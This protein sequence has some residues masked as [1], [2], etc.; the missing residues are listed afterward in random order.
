MPRRIHASQCDAHDHEKQRRPQFSGL[1][2]T[3]LPH[4]ERRDQDGRQRHF[5]GLH[6][7]AVLAQKIHGRLVLFRQACDAFHLHLHA[8]FDH[9]GLHDRGVDSVVAGQDRLP[10]DLEARFERPVRVGDGGIQ[11][12]HRQVARSVGDIQRRGQQAGRRCQLDPPQPLQQAQGTAFVGGGVRCADQA[13][14]G[15]SGTDGQRMETPAAILLGEILLTGCA[16]ARPLP[17]DMS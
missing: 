6:R 1:K 17:P 13:P 3:G 7:R 9:A 12:L 2:C 10:V 15:K 5:H 8:A 14:F 11:F 16:L 4:A